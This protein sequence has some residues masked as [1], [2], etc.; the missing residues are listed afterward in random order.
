MHFILSLKPS[1]QPLNISKDASADIWYILSPASTTNFRRHSCDPAIELYAC[2][3][4]LAY[5]ILPPFISNAYQLQI[6]NTLAG[7]VFRNHC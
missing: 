2:R 3:S 4:I 6:S 7:V 1:T 5:H